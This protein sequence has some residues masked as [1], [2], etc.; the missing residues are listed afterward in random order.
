MWAFISQNTTEFLEVKEKGYT[1]SI[2]RMDLRQNYSIL[3]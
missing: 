2:G 3:I 1:K